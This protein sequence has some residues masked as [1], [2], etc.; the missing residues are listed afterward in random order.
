[1]T[2]R[3]PNLFERLFYSGALSSL[4]QFIAAVRAQRIQ[5]D[6]PDLS[7]ENF[8]DPSAAAAASYEPLDP[9][10]RLRFPSLFTSDLYLSQADRADYRAVDP[11]LMFFMHKFIAALRKQGVPM[12][13]HSALRTEAEQALLVRQG[14]SKTVYPNAAHCRG[15]AV[16]IVHS[17]Y[18]WN[19]K[20]HEWA[21]IGKIGEDI[22]RQYRLPITW[23]G[24]WSFYDPAH[25]EITD[26]R[27]LPLPAP[28]G[29]PKRLT[30]IAASKV[31]LDANP[32]PLRSKQ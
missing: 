2:N 26:W 27:S 14:R 10:G 5:G 3:T 20:P 8:I 25:W 31:F 6:A 18:A 7:F 16:D 24:R 9:F 19:L 4:S 21:Y 13:V 23:G 29:V 17:K 30:P 1:M 22:I 11:R 32:K 12:F 15:G 28:S